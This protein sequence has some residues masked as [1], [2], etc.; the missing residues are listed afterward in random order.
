MLVEIRIVL[1]PVNLL[2]NVSNYGTFISE[3]IKTRIY[4]IRFDLVCSLEIM[5][6]AIS[7]TFP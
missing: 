1:I 2:E 5:K 4:Q 7:V 3:Q 6:Q